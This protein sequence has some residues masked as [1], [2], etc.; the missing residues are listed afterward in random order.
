MSTLF[1]LLHRAG[2]IADATYD[3]HAGAGALTPRQLSAL[4]VVA[5]NP[6]VSQTYIVEQTGIDRSTMADMMNR[7]VDA[8]I[9]TRKR[10]KEDARAYAV[11]LTAA[12]SRAVRSAVIANTNA[13]SAVLERIPQS[14]LKALLAG[15]NN[16]IAA[17]ERTVLQAAE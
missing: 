2:Q 12:G 14:Q 1:D 17:Q 9:I 13:E 7:L 4:R 16:I 10:T 6:G 3:T 15:L 8:G 11:T 5:D